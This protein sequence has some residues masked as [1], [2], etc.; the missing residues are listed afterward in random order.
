MGNL[1]CGAKRRFGF[2]VLDDSASGGT[3]D[4]NEKTKAAILAALQK[5]DPVDLAIDGA[6]I[7]LQPER[8]LDGKRLRGCGHARPYAPVS[9]SPH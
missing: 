5:K 3:M 2:F 8:H 4:K 1:E 9:V 6:V 7:S